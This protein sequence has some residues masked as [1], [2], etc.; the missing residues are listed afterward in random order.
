MALQLPFATI[1]TIAFSSSPEIM[2]EF[3]NGVPNIV[4]SILL[5]IVV[6]AIN[7]FFIASRVHVH[8]LSWMWITLVG[9]YHMS[10]ARVLNHLL[11]HG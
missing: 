6:I 4:I 2:G 10:L 3:V 11:I 1:P 9:E 8:E 5:S 7:L